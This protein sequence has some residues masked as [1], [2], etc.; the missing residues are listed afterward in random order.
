MKE[1][2]FRKAL[3]DIKKAYYHDQALLIDRISELDALC[4]DLYDCSL[5]NK[6]FNCPNYVN[7][8]C[9]TRVHSRFQ[10]MKNFQNVI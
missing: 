1:A 10:E 7:N 4:R 2:M 6:C 5:E 3:E 8:I 9:A